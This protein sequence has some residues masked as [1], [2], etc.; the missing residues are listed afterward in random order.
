MVPVTAT[1]YLISARPF[2]P[3]DHPVEVPAIWHA[4]QLVL[5]GVFEGEA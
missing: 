3:M 1:Q 5:S 4:F 2:L